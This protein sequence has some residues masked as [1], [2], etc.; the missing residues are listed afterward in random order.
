MEEEQIELEIEQPSR[1]E[2]R[3]TDDDL[4]VLRDQM[5]RKDEE[6][7]SLSKSLEEERKRSQASNSR[8][9]DEIGNRFSAE[10]IAVENAILAAGSELDTLEKQQA[11][12]QE[13]G[14]F[15]E[16]SKL[17]RLIAGA[18]LKLEKSE[19]QKKFL[20]SNKTKL[21][22]EIE[23]QKSDPLAAYSPGAKN[24]IN[25]HPK[26]LT[27]GAYKS[28]ALAAHY[29]AES[30]GV[31]EASNPSEYFKRLTDSV[32]PKITVNVSQEDE[33]EESEPKEPAKPV[34]QAS[35]TSTAAPVSRTT[36]SGSVNRGGQRI[37]LTPDEAEAAIISR[38][39][40]PKE[41]A[42]KRYFTN[43]QRAIADG[44]LGRSA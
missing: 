9:G 7:A 39:D 19:E 15:G 6:N 35:R 32:E 38:P 25:A 30:D 16:A 2:A 14:K 27:D 29:Q 23:A 21:Q 36:S 17:N 5:K 33:V 24:W 22:A 40:L 44:K 34:R 13:E 1:K 43:K 4:N 20:E 18:A 26:F 8:L 28:K 41:E 10:T 12:L 42:Y 31:T 3:V 37:Q 11:Q